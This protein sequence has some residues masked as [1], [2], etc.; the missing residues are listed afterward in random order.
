M[1]SGTHTEVTLL[2]PL[3]F[4][5]ACLL[6]LAGADSVVVF[7]GAAVAALLSDQICVLVTFCG[8]SSSVHLRTAIT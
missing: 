3:N 6:S 1:M 2:D 4:P 5:N 8:K 7:A